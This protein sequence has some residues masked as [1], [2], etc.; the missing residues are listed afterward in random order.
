M[1]QHSDSS[2][3][4]LCQGGHG[5]SSGSLPQTFIFPSPSWTLKSLRQL[6]LLLIALK[7]SPRRE[8]WDLD[9]CACVDQSTTRGIVPQAPSTFYWRQ[10][11]SLAW[12]LSK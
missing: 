8:R 9:V 3:K 11:R 1:S 7:P 10:G 12:N 2:L 5:R 6:K 4:C